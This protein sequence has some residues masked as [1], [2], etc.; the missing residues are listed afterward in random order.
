M[1]I[2]DEICVEITNQREKNLEKMFNMYGFSKDY[3]LNHSDEFLVIEHDNVRRYSHNGKE[4]FDEIN[5]FEN[6]EFVTK[7]IP[8]T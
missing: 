6:N 2:I 7:Y 1:N 3:L 8:L 4:L 5:T